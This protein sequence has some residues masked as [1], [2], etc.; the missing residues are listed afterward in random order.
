[1]LMKTYLAWGFA[2]LTGFAI[3]GS[4]GVRVPQLPTGTRGSSGYYG[5]HGS[6]GYGGS[7]GFG[8]GK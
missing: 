5:G 6:G 4:T 2:V 8:W 7:S 3:L 1:M